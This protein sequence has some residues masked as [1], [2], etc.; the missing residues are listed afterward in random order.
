MSCLTVPE[1]VIIG[2]IVGSLSTVIGSYVIHR[3]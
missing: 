1:I 2:F 3:R